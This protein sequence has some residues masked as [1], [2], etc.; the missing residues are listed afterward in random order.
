MTLGFEEELA[1]SYTASYEFMFVSIS[2]A[3]LAED[4]T[5]NHTCS[6]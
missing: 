2:K 5:T 6:S 4:E 3:R 1:T